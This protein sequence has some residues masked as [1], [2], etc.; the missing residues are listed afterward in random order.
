M[1]DNLTYPCNRR[2]SLVAYR[3]HLPTT[4]G[5][6]DAELPIRRDVGQVVTIDHLT[7]DDLLAIFDFHVFKDQ[8]L[9]LPELSA[10]DTKR[11]IESWQSLVQVCRRWRGLV[12]ASPHRLNLQLFC[13]TGGYA[14]K[15]LDVWPA[16]PIVI[17]GHVYDSSVNNVITKLKHS[18]RIYQIDVHCHSTSQIQKLWTAIQVP[19]PKLAVLCLSLEDMT[20][21]LWSY[22]NFVR[23]SSSRFIPGWICATSTIPRLD[24]HS[25]SGVTESAFVCHSPRQT[26]AFSHSSFLVH[27]TRGDGH[28]SLHV[29]QPRGT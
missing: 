15:S 24:L 21:R 26:L 20:S 12:F 4:S 23:G 13:V 29:D 16:L 19:F 8:V 28:L 6:F 10:R 1:A 9:D 27:F 14:R 2:K 7:D 17:Q 3:H 18:N 5:R 25:I 11:K 22:R